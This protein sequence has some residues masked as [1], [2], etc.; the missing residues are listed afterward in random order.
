MKVSATEGSL[1]LY[2]PNVPLVSHT[3]HISYETP[4]VGKKRKTHPCNS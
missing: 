4:V 1:L 3:I 2:N